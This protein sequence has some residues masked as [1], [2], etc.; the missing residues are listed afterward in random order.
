MKLYNS[1]NK[2]IE[3]FKP[4][5]DKNVKMYV[6]G[7]TVYGPAHIGNI[8]PAI[9]FDQ[10]FRILQLKY[11]SGSVTY[12]RNI[13]D[14]DDKIIFTSI[15]KNVSIEE[16]T[17]AAIE[18]Y[19]GDL[20]RLNVLSPS[21]EP[22]A[23][24][25]ITGMRTMIKRLVESDHAYV[26]NGEVF[27]HVPSS[28]HFPLTV[29]DDLISGHRVEVNGKKKDPRDFVLWKPAKENEPWW[30][31]PWGKGR[32]GWHIEC[33]AMIATHLGERTI[34]IHGGGQDLKFPHHEAECAQTH[35]A[36]GYELA[37]YWVH[38]G[39]LTVDGEKMSKSRGNVIYAT[40]ILEKYHGE[41]LRFYFLKTH[42]RNHMDFTMEGLNESFSILNKFYNAFDRYSHVEHHFDAEIPEKMIELLYS[43]MNVPGYI[44]ELYEMLSELE[45]STDKSSILSKLLT[46]GNLIGIFEAGSE[47]K[48]F[49]VD[50]E[51]IESIMTKRAEARMNREWAVS[52]QLRNELAENGITVLDHT[53][54]STWQLL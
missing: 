31:S 5:D 22:R 36:N 23:T 2:S 26:R 45:T 15:E 53:S 9:V 37:N 52:D 35:A 19:H 16:I 14:V 24:E 20:S 25:S 42:Y 6:C 29:N 34:D 17:T 46:A 13:T 32:P 12:A 51:Y 38:N 10:L 21:V 1:Q 47:W 44:S 7:P 8:R 48:T 28:T 41:V 49:N 40:D 11:G 30:N 39:M 54:G 43:D 50:V 27:F 4:I 18:Q 3:D 33:S